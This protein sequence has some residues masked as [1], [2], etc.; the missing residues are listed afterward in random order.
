LVQNMLLYEACNFDPI[1]AHFDRIGGIAQMTGWR[2][3]L[4]VV[5][6]CFV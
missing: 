3:V 6:T 2:A 5:F 1:V 4:Y